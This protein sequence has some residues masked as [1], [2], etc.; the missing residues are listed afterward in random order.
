MSNLLQKPNIEK[1]QGDRLSYTEINALDNAIDSV[2]DVVNRELMS[3]CNINFECTG[4]SPNLSQEFTLSSAI[5]LIN[6]SRRLPGFIIK[7]L[8]KETKTWSEFQYN[9]QDTSP[10]SWNNLN[11]WKRINPIQI[12]DGG[13]F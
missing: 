13:T 8:D 6:I 9:S 7:F 1:N 2:I 3:F 10:D 11:N 4:S 5:E 12:I